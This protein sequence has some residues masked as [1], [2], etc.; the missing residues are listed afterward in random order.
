M[1]R[2]HLQ[3]EAAYYRRIGDT[4]SQIAMEAT[5][6][7]AKTA[8]AAEAARYYS[9]AERMERAHRE[10][11]IHERAI[12]IFETTTGLEYTTEH[13]NSRDWAYARDRAAEEASTLA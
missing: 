7:P 4:Y 11:S 2:A 3:H 12:E 9:I 8:N 6:A 5:Y 1:S 10:N 13:A